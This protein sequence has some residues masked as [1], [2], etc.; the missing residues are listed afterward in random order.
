M[1]YFYKMIDTPLGQLTLVTSN[2]GIAALLWQDEK[3]KY[4]HLKAI[5]KVDTHPILMEAENQLSAYFSGQLQQFDL[6][7]DFQGTE[8]Q[9]QVWRALLTIPFGKTRSYGDIAKQIGNPKAMRAIGAANGRNAISIIVP[10]H[11]V[12]GANNQLTGFA[13]GLTA[14][15]YLLDLEKNLNFRYL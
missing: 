14:K 2:K 15:A 13:G 6:K 11:R 12:I 3:R 8:F 5:E 9:K 10:C 7:L 1:T 4:T